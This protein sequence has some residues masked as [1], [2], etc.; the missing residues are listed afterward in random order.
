MTE[1]TKKIRSYQWMIKTSDGR[2]RGCHDQPEAISYALEHQGTVKRVATFWVTGA[3]QVRGGESCEFH[4][5][6]QDAE[7]WVKKERERLG[8]GWVVFIYK[9]W[10]GES[11]PR[12]RLD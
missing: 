6:K 2:V 7:A 10:A 12:W 5:N 11:H 4:W 3:S 8:S 9:A 1:P